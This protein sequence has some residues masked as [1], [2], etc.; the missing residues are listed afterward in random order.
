MGK[1]QL[2]MILVVIMFLFLLSGCSDLVEVQD[3]DFVL[4]MGV[5]IKDESF[6]I[7]L[8][9]PRYGKD[10]KEEGSGNE[11][12]I[13]EFNCN[14]ISE[15]EDKFNF[16]SDKRLDYRHL[17]VIILA[18]SI[19]SNKSKLKELIDY[20][21]SSYEISSNVL[22]FYY[23]GNV[24]DVFSMEEVLSKSIG[25]YIK[26]L[27]D[28]N[29]EKFKIKP[30]T[31]GNL[32]SAFSQEKPIIIPAI[33]VLEEQ[34]RVS[35]AAV[36]Y[37]GDVRK[38]FADYEYIMA[39]ISK[40][41]GKNYSIYI[42]EAVPIIIKDIDSRLSYEYTEGRIIVYVD[43]KADIEK[44][45]SSSNMSEDELSLEVSEYLLN[46]ISTLL[47]DCMKKDL[48]DVLRIYDFAAIKCRQAFIDYEGKRE[49][50]LKDVEVVISVE[51]CCK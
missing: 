42:M 33:K 31:I 50:F 24:E 22:V 1:K 14:Y 8:A 47:E 2:K 13:L 19:A 44:I 11:K 39:L 28:N 23:A 17:E 30:V 49:E 9:E 21:K 3:R 27:D 43:V 36:L 37:D 26:K 6:N 5:S 18:D 35:G 46:G 4:A 48:L 15:I 10:T 12:S 51:V 32:I 45:V 7:Y 40:G 20:L 29:R 16:T 41:E 25:D 34:I 38:I